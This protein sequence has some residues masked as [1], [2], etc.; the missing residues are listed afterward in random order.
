MQH[1]KQFL[2]W[3]S[4]TAAD[5]LEPRQSRSRESTNAAWQAQKNVP[6]TAFEECEE[7]TLAP[8]YADILVTPPKI[9][10]MGHTRLVRRADGRV[11]IVT[12]NSDQVDDRS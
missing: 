2:R 1:I 3:K 12:E 9:V 8:E 7:I 4:K 10:V 5:K 6:N 11:Y